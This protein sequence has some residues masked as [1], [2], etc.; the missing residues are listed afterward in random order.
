MLPESPQ[1]RVGGEAS[2]RPPA[3][4]IASSPALLFQQSLGHVICHLNSHTNTVLSQTTLRERSPQP[5]LQRELAES[6]S[7]PKTLAYEKR[8]SDPRAGLD[9][10]G[11]Q[12]TLSAHP[13]FSLP[14]PHPAPHAPGCLVGR[15]NYEQAASGR[16]R[17]WSL[18][19]PAPDGLRF[20]F[21][22]MGS[23]STVTSLPTS[24]AQECLQSQC[25]SP[26]ACSA[27]TDIPVFPTDTE[28]PSRKGSSEANNPLLPRP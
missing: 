27:L 18:T 17:P 2:S 25:D 9:K 23:D 22:G 14:H 28:R 12:T 3:H 19:S 4:W 13:A 10:S 15:R 24:G 7:V 21:Q 16:N 20:R 1:R 8:E 26:T 11:S 5:S 6:T